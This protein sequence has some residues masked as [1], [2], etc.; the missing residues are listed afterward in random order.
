MHF[1]NKLEET[2]QPKAFK[3]F[4]NTF[5]FNPCSPNQQ[6]PLTT[7]EK[8]AFRQLANQ[9]KKSIKKYGTLHYEE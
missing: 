4:R 9:R 2:C 8:R 7:N 3:A 1:V 6:R 5:K